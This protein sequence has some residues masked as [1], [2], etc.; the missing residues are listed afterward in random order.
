MKL[1]VISSLEHYSA[2]GRIVCAWPAAVREIDALATLFDE[3]VHVGCLHSGA[4][5]AQAIP[6]DAPNLRVELLEPAGGPGVYGKVDALRAL[7]GRAAAIERAWQDAD[8]VLVRC[9][10]NV[11][12]PALALMALGRGPA[13]KWV[14][15]AGAW[16]GRPGEKLTHRLQRYW[17]RTRLTGAEVTVGGLDPA[18]G[19]GATNLC[20][21]SLTAAE[22]WAAD[23]ATRDKTL[24][25][26][27]RLLS[28]GRLAPEKG[29]DIAIRAVALVAAQGR[30]VELDIA[31][32]GPERVAL[33]ALAEAL[34]IRARVR[35]H[36][37]LAEPQLDGLYARAHALLAPSLAEGW[38]R[39]WTD[40]AARRCVPVAADV[41]AARGLERARAG[42]VIP[43]H[44]PARWAAGLEDLLAA[45][46]AWRELAGRG[47]ALARGF[48][49]ERFLDG[50]RVA[51][52]LDAGPSEQ[53]AF[54]G[55]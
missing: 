46:P 30:A 51:L 55:V 52:G 40:A 35:F 34:G 27:C 16:R 2:G 22:V 13:R 9:P 44:D 15:Y 48:T 20:N 47:P 4:A 38:S 5:P 54:E 8:A 6:Y 33:E 1:A 39:T 31:G 41:G 49:C 50:A 42:V 45:E 19:G 12:A 17:L 28:A 29:V 7:P 32:G 26:P 14:K 37:W 3:V 10:S 23:Y 36:G 25:S 11:A 24:T 43:S 21:P 53:E 18:P